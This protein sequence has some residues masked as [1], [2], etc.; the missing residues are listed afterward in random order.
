MASND[1]GMLEKLDGAVLKYI[2]LGEAPVTTVWNMI[3]AVG[4]FT[5]EILKKVPSWVGPSVQV[6]V[7]LGSLAT[8]G[9]DVREACAQ[10]A[11]RIM[12]G[13]NLLDRYPADKKD[14][15]D[16]KY[17]TLRSTLLE[18]VEKH[19]LTKTGILHDICN[20]VQKDDLFSDLN[21]IGTD[22]G[23]FNI[24]YAAVGFHHIIGQNDHNLSQNALIIS[25][26]KE[27][28][29]ETKEFRFLFGTSRSPEPQPKTLKPAPEI[30]G[31]ADVISKLVTLFTKTEEHAAVYGL[32]GMGKSSIA[33][34]VAHHPIIIKKFPNRLFYPC[35]TDKSVADLT[36]GLLRLILQQEPKNES[37]HD[38]LLEELAKL[39][40]FLVIDNFESVWYDNISEAEKFVAQLAG[41]PTLTLLITTGGVQKHLSQTAEE[42]S[43]QQR[44]LSQDSSRRYRTC[45]LPPRHKNCHYSRRKRVFTLQ[46]R[47]ENH[48][49]LAQISNKLRRSHPRSLKQPCSLHLAF[50]LEPPHNRAT[51]RDGSLRFLAR[52]PDGIKF[53]WI[54]RCGP[55][56]RKAMEASL[57]DFSKI[58]CRVTL[59]PPIAEYFRSR[60]LPTP[61]FIDRF[62]VVAQ[63]DYGE[64][65][66]SWDENSILLEVGADVL[67]QE[68]KPTLSIALKSIEDY[69]DP[70]VRLSLP[71]NKFQ[72]DK[73][74]EVAAITESPLLS[75]FW[76][77]MEFR[78]GTRPS[79]VEATRLLVEFE[80]SMDCAYHAGFSYCRGIFKDRAS[81]F[82]PATPYMIRFL[83]RVKDYIINAAYDSE[84][85]LVLFNGLLDWFHDYTASYAC[86]I[87]EEIGEP[88][89]GAPGDA[90]LGLLLKTFPDEVPE[91]KLS[92]STRAQVLRK[93]FN[94]Q[95]RS[96]RDFSKTI[97]AL[98]AALEWLI[99]CTS[100]NIDLPHQFNE[101]SE[102]FIE[103][104]E[105]M[106]QTFVSAND[107]TWTKRVLTDAARDNWVP[108][109]PVTYN[110]VIFR[111]EGWE[112]LMAVPHASKVDRQLA[113][114]T[115]AR[116][117][118]ESFTHERNSS[119][120]VV[121]AMG[122]L[123]TG[124][125]WLWLFTIR[126]SAASFERFEGI[127]ASEIAEVLIEIRTFMTQTFLSADDLT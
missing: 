119:D 74:E 126:C 46:Q 28:L 35:H 59:R 91:N 13:T 5:V 14:D 33:L 68:P 57:A 9:A 16:A 61:M 66:T 77:I 104:R 8:A 22:Y 70:F 71:L 27:R 24:D 3:T 56:F 114:C 41:I 7:M 106:T 1:P 85:I 105:F 92:V 21:Q 25:I 18:V 37:K 116:I 43:L 72:L 32:G 75:K 86:K 34:N 53:E 97:H 117:L 36:I 108:N 48:R 120:K 84:D 94:I 122:A 115:K 12:C 76:Q 88:V 64:K 118:S 60:G 127:E 10:V 39:T 110:E 29:H 4:G 20:G 30:Y 100:I 98:S 45:R 80:D 26:K 38:A 90:T 81:D 17:E 79:S 49:G 47:R 96:L 63:A 31:R 44:S 95:R 87:Y 2:H 78:M 121:K 101:L 111:L 42:C 73:M 62:L 50:Y 15:L 67:I 83:T 19:A 40:T 102:V 23:N 123:D 107:L 65:F 124:L 58:N 93:S 11:G 125:K 51:F 109:F 82:S 113:Y 55:D 6:L 112:D 52:F 69:V 99:L 103:I 89:V 54:N